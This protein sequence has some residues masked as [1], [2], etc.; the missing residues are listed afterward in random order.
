MPCTPGEEDRPS[1]NFKPASRSAVLAPR[2]THAFTA[3]VPDGA[4]REKPGPTGGAPE[5]A[6]RPS[7]PLF[8]AAALGGR[9]Q[10]VAE[11]P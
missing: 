4:P 1:A 7:G 6:E 9:P 10:A 11:K 8:R 3:V 5:A 2:R